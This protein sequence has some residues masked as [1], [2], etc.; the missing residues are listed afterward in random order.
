MG[1]L[2]L[3]A[4]ELKSLGISPAIVA[5]IA[6]PISLGCANLS[7]D[8]ANSFMLSGCILTGVFTALTDGANGSIPSTAD[9]GG[10]VGCIIPSGLIC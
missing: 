5:P 6:V 3:L 10:I 2:K 1:K 9:T 8:A 7:C 4:K